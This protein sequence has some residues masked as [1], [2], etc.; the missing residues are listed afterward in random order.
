MKFTLRDLLWLTLVLAL[1]L[2]WF[3]SDRRRDA[4]L[5][6]TTDRHNKW[7]DEWKAET[8]ETIEGY[9]KA[10][11]DPLAY[12]EFVYKRNQEVAKAQQARAQ[13]SNNENE[14]P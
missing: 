1:A 7:L 2:S 9:R 13:Q 5:R 11:L 12:R 4:E 8:S 14:L 10:A 3:N 6:A